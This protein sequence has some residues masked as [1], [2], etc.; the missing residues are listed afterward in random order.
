MG[1]VRAGLPASL[2]PVWQVADLPSPLL[3]VAIYLSIWYAQQATNLSLT[4]RPNLIWSWF[5]LDTA[6]EA[7]ATGALLWLLVLKPRREHGAL[8]KNQP[9][10]AGL[11]LRA[12]ETN[13]LS[14]VFHIVTMALFGTSSS[15]IYSYT[16]PAFCLTNIYAINLFS[17][18]LSRPALQPKVATGYDTN[19]VSLAKIQVVSEVEVEVSE[20]TAAQRSRGARAYEAH[21]DGPSLCHDLQ[22]IELGPGS[23]GSWSEDRGERELAEWEKGPRLV[24]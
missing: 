8:L 14:L 19:F 24:D 22:D 21:Y 10:L 12:V 13:F 4:T 3:P 11:V 5:A 17:Q 2:P 18:L 15:T 7:L 6:S 9:V 23:G 1:E 16:V 20:P